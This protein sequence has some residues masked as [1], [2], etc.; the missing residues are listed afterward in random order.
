MADGGD[1]IAYFVNHDP[2]PV[3]FIIRYLYTFLYVL[4]IAGVNLEFWW[5]ASKFSDICFWL[6]S[7]QL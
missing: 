6:Q 3:L 1:H 5:I 7:W 4:K 2:L